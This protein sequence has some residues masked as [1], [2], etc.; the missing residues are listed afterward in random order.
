MGLDSLFERGVVALERIAAALETRLELVAQPDQPMT[1][2]AAEPE[3]KPRG[4]PRKDA[5]P[6]KA[7]VDATNERAVTATAVAEAT[8]VAA[9]TTAARSFLDDEDEPAAAAPAVVPEFT[10]KE[11]RDEIRKRL[12]ALQKALSPEQALKVLTSAG[13]CQIL[14]ELKPENFK[15]VYEAIDKAMPKAAA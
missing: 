7:N 6:E 3:R 14:R 15:A 10:E 5:Q 12:I 2:V 11:H 8:T 4:R 1:I 13:K 9:P